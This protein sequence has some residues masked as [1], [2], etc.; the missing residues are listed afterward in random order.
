MEGLNKDD[1]EEKSHK[2]YYKDDDTP[3]GFCLCGEDQN[4]FQNETEH[5]TRLQ[6]AG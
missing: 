5:K 3:A 2:D 6:S 1:G 4:E